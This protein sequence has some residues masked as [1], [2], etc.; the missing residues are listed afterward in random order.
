LSRHQRRESAHGSSA[1]FPPDLE[2]SLTLTPEPVD[3]FSFPERDIEV[4]S[5]VEPLSVQRRSLTNLFLS[6]YSKT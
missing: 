3:P 5:F 1:E 6:T 4:S 2:F